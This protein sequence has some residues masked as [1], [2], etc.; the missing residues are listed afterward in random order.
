MR[1]T[2]LLVVLALWP[3]WVSAQVSIDDVPRIAQAV[4]DAEGVNLGAGST[5]EYRNAFWA[6]VVGIIH[7]GH[8][9][10]NPGKADASWCI[11][12]G[13]NGRPQSDDVIV[14]CQSREFWDCIP[15]AGAAG[16]SFRCHKDAARLPPE[17]N[18]YA[19]PRPSGSSGNGGG[20]G[21][22]GG[23]PPATPVDL[24]PVLAAVTEL[25]TKVD[26]VAALALAARDAAQDARA[27]AEQAKVNASDV[28]HLAVPELKAL[29][30]AFRQQQYEIDGRVPF[31][32]VKGTIRPKAQE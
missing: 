3:A 18:V 31:G 4:H 29:I 26:A 21:T 32:S 27:E 2:V 5:R 15:G 22:G 25:A 1:R 16:Y 6:R 17:Q 11:K 13:G 24:A 20:G 12:D 23:T 10:Y 7:W 19:P 14:Q 9:V 8:P 28:K 30:E